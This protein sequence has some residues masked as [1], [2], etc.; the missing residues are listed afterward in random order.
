MAAAFSAAAALLRNFHHLPE[1]PSY[2]LSS[3]SFFIKSFNNQTDILDRNEQLQLDAYKLK[4]KRVKISIFANVC[5]F[6][7]FNAGYYLALGYGAYRLSQGL[8]TF[9]TLTAMLQ[10][11]GKIQSPFK[12][13]SSMIPQIFSVSASVERIIE[14]E[15]MPEEVSLT[16]GGCTYDELEK[17]VFDNVTFGYEADK[18]VMKNASFEINK[19]EFV[20]IGGESG[21]G[22]STAI[23]LMLGIM[24]PNSGEIFVKTDKGNFQLGTA[25]RE[26]FAYV[27]QGNL[28]LSGT[29]R[30]NVAFGKKNASDEDIIKALELAQIWDYISTL[31]NGLDTVLGEKGLGLSEGQIQRI[32]IARAL[33][34]DA[35]VLLLDESTSAL[36]ERTE[37]ELL[38]TLKNMTDK[39]CIIISHKKAA[40]DFCDKVIDYG[41]FKENYL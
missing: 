38:T 21:I 4:L 9:G 24:S 22:K 3:S 33:L 36:D 26:L 30:E 19:G 34:Y 41:N 40:F 17:I 6:I 11:V 39:T 23:K 27:P 35:P 29:I 14:L 1:T 7:F 13:I 32:S 16:Q 8:I 10:L 18:P 5:M 31:E 15:E 25:T 28:I 20:V 12:D 2:F 37:V